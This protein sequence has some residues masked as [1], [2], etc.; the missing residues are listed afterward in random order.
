VAPTE[1]LKTAVN[2][3]DDADPLLGVTDT[4]LNTAVIVPRVTLIED[5]RVLPAP[6]LATT[7]KVFAPIARLTE[8]LQFAVLLP[9]AVPPV[10]LV[11]F[12]VTLVMPLPPAPLS[13]AV[14]LN[15]M[16]EVETV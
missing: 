15:V 6:S 12:T 4:A 2:V 11:P 3:C 13:V 1:S 16:L 7:V 14:P 10:A 5:V 9:D 8:R